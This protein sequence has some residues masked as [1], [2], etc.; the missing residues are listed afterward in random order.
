MFSLLFLASASEDD[1]TDEVPSPPYQRVMDSAS[2]KLLRNLS[3]NGFAQQ[4]DRIQQQI[5]AQ[6]LLFARHL[7]SLYSMTSP[8]T[9]GANGEHVTRLTKR[10]N[11]T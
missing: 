1:S 6:A 5:L 3:E 10:Q 8:P 11:V 2:E 9:V 7:Q 4:P